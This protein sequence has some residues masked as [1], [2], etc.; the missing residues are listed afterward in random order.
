[1]AYLISTGAH[2]HWVRSITAHTHGNGAL[3]LTLRGDAGASDTQFNEAEI[4]IFTDNAV[5]TDRLVK[6]INDVAELPAVTDEI[7]A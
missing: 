3:H 2:Y 6:A 1:M 7:A 5:L 4:T